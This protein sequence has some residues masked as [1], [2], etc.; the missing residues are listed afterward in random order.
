[1]NEESLVNELKDVY[2]SSFKG[3]RLNYRDYV[4]ADTRD[5]TE[6]FNREEKFS[7]PSKSTKNHEF[8]ISKITEIVSGSKHI[9]IH[10]HDR[11]DG[12]LEYEVHYEKNNGKWKVK[13]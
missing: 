1:M 3:K 12:S 6:F 7:S 9:S 5:I 13:D 4:L 8:N 2:L 11:T 10:Y